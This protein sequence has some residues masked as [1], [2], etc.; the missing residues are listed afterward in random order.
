MTIKVSLEKRMSQE[1]MGKKE[2]KLTKRRSNVKTSFVERYKTR[3]FKYHPIFDKLKEIN[4]YKIIEKLTSTQI[5]DYL[6]YSQQY[7]LVTIKRFHQTTLNA[8]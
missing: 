5:L 1:Q 4:N 8:S 6:K 2:G 3:R 7:D